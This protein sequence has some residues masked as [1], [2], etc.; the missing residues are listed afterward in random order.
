[1]FGEFLYETIATIAILTLVVIYFLTKY[2]QQEEENFSTDKKYNTPKTI[3]DV[4]EI[5]EPNDIKTTP[6]TQEDKEEEPFILNGGEE[7]SFGKI[8]E[9]PFEGNT[10]APKEKIIKEYRVKGKVPEHGKISKGTF[11][12]FSGVK[13]LIAEDNLINQKVLNG[14]LNESGIEITMADDGQVALD[15]LE[16]NSDFNMVLMDAHMPRVDGFEAT[17]AIR[18]NP[19]YEHI[20]V[21]ALSGDTA[22]DDVKKMYEAG[23]QEHL[24][25]PLRMDALYD[26]LYAYTKTTT[27]NEE[28]E[29]INVIMTKELNGDKG[30]EI[31][32][33]DED[34]YRDILDE[35]VKKYSSSSKEL[36]ELVENSKLREADAMLLDLVGI[37][38]N[39]GADNINGIANELKE[40]IKDTEEKSYITLLDEYETHLKIL[41]HDIRDYK[42]L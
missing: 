40:A 15:I 17:R 18:A 28:S 11:K 6:K 21:V 31:C 26:V 35:F 42:E 33:G 10:T 13:I 2:F 27:E 24:E 19:N 12:E 16:K 32:G 41:I 4:Q 20:V 9:N 22:A 8:V 29:F 36:K 30:L 39:I 5:D 37:S 34:F 23:M 14:L 38:A 3:D 1:M 25:K 7:G